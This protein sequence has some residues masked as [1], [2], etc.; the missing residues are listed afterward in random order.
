MKTVVI[1][2]GNSGIG[3]GIAELFH[4][5]NFFVIVAGR[6]DYGLEKNFSKNFIFK[7]LDL[8]E[9]KSHQDLVNLALEKTGKI[10]CYINNIGLS[11]WKPLSL[12]LIHI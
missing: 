8:R 11:A 6:K 10:N 7:S 5:N 9:E 4:K 3:L 2:G 12:S 1:T